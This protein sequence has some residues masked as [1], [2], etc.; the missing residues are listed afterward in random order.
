MY[1]SGIIV[2]LAHGV[3]IGLWVARGPRSQRETE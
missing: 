1:L 3:F 2:G